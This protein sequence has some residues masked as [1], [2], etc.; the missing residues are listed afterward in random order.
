MKKKKS[1]IKTGTIV[2]RSIYAVLTLSLIAAICYGLWHLWHFLEAYE[3]SQPEIPA[4]AFIN[5]IRKNKTLYFDKLEFTPN[6]YEEKS[7]AEDYFNE[8]INS[9]TTYS[10]NGRESNDEQT[11]YTLKNGKDNIASITVKSSGK[12]LGYGFHEY[13]VTD[14]K[15]GKIVTSAYSV[16][17]PNNA[18]LYCNGKEV[19]QSYIAETGSPGEEIKYFHE[20]GSDYFHDNVYTIDGFVRE[21]TFTAKNKAGELL[22]LKDGR[23][24]SVPEKNEELSQLACSFAQSYSKFLVGDEK[25]SAVTSYLAP[26]MQL[27]DDLV[28]F[29]N[30]WSFHSSYEIKNEAI[31]D[32]FFYSDNSASVRV[33]YDHIMYGVSLGLSPS[34][35]FTT[36]ADY[37]VYLVKLENEWKVTDIVIN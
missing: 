13:E 20:L 8:L 5:E 14:V 2:F 11:V 25:L 33:T 10:R 3:K 37:T 26:N 6:Y 16:T 27:Y 18:V 29:D 30:R 15:F 23:F 4:T 17:V 9:I 28:G 32:P 1:K 22:E 12:E 21:P 7:Y 24:S 36:H 19:S 34:G 35:E 31:Y